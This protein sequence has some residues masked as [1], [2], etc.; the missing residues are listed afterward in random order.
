MRAL[1]IFMV[2][3][4]FVLVNLICSAKVSFGSR[5]RPSILGNGFVARIL[6]LMLRLRDLE[7]SAGSGV[8]RV[9]WVLLVLRMR[10]MRVA[11]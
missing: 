4:A 10:L 2:L 7:Y 11:Q 3:Y 8:K 9:V 1:Y 6:L 5:V